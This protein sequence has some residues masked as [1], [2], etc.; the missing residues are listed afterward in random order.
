[1]LWGECVGLAAG[2]AAG[3]VASIPDGIAHSFG[4]AATSAVTWLWQQVS[5]ATTID[6]TNPG[7]RSDLVITAA[8]AAVIT[9]A[10]FCIQIIGSA[11]RGSFAGLGRSV[12]GLLIAFVGAVFA[13]T[14]TD[15]TLT[16]VDALANGVVQTAAQQNLAQVGES[17]VAV[18]GLGLL[19]WAGLLLMSLVILLAVAVIWC[20]LMIRKMLIIVAAV[21]AP[22]AFSGATADITK[23]WVRRWIEFTV[24]LIFSK[25]ILVVILLIGLSMVDGAGSTGGTSN[26]IT[27][28]AIGTLTLLLA[29]F[30]PWLAIKMVH[31]AGDA[32]HHV[33]AQAGAAGVGAATAIAAPQKAATLVGGAKRAFVGSSPVKSAAWAGA[34]K[35]VGHL[36]GGS[37]RSPGTSAS[38]SSSSSAAAGQRAAVGVGVAELGVDGP[39][40]ATP[41]NEFASNSTGR[42]P[43]KPAK[44]SGS[45]A[46]GATPSRPE[47]AG[48][49]ATGAPGGTQGTTTTTTRAP[50]GSSISGG[51]AG[52]TSKVG[53]AASATGRTDRATDTPVPTHRPSRTIPRAA[54]PTTPSP[55]RQAET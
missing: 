32:F 9:V 12:R 26:E 20:A 43:S 14:A 31:F 21:F 40:L 17:L 28:L 24:A 25:L 34:T 10:L 18:S 51:S 16:A 27:N 6:P 50:S 30:A 15:L 2:N 1:M 41:P 3:A 33:H 7:V 39:Q 37:H 5:D 54:G 22:I 23:G 13:I 8:I 45:P 11:L 19:G 47:R 52:A 36:A 44:V 46:A 29:G 42:R 4:D 55:E 35:P 49:D 48:P 53:G 38:P